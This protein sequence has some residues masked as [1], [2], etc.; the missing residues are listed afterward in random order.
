M[1]EKTYIKLGMFSGPPVAA[2]ARRV[3]F[4]YKNQSMI[5][6]GQKP[7]FLFLGDSIIH[8]WEERAFFTQPGQLIINRGIAGD[9][10]TYLNKRL[11]AD[12]LQ[13]NPTYCILG[14][15]SNDSIAL[16]GNHFAG[17]PPMPYEDVVNKAIHNFTE[18]FEKFKQTEIK[19]LV[20]SIPPL[21][22]PVLQHPDDVNRFV[23]DMNIWLK[24]TCEKEGFIYLDYYNALVTPG[25]NKIQATLTFDGLHPNAY[26]Y[27]AMATVLRDTLAEKGVII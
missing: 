3:E 18:I 7:D 12:A 10:T 27:E 21:N 19:L 26:G 15:G 11:E 24:A 25:T 14:I 23:I 13:L 5:F 1:E 9:T 8:F 20:G 2:D 16:E 6:M 17:I 22:I 4:N